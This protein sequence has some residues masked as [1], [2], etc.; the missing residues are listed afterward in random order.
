MLQTLAEG[1]CDS[2]PVFLF[3]R[4]LIVLDKYDAQARSGIFMIDASRGFAKD[5]PK[6]R[7][8]PR[9]VHRIVDAFTG[10]K[11]IEGY[12]RM[13]P[14]SEIADP[15]NNYNL[16]IPRYIDSSEPEDIQDLHAHIHG[17]IPN[18]DLD[19]LQPYWEAFPSLR[20]ELFA[21][22]REGYS[23]LKVEPSEIRTT[24][25]GSDEY[26]SFSSDTAATVQQWWAS[27]RPLLEGIDAETKPA[28]LIDDISE[29]LL[30]AFR[31]RP[32]I[33]E[34]GVYEQ[35]MSYWNDV[36]HDDVSLIVREGWTQ[37]VQPRPARMWRDKK[38]KPKYED[39]HIV[40]GI[41]A[42]AQRW[43]LDLLPPEHVIARY[44]ADEQAELDRLT[45]VRDAAT[46][47]V[48]EYIEEHAVEGG[49][50]FYAA[51]DEGKLPKK[52]AA[53][54]LK[55]LR[56]D[57]GDPEEV[58]A[59]TKVAALYR[60][61]DSAKKAVKDATT[62]LNEKTVAKYRVLTDADAQ[63]LVISSKWGMTLRGRIDAEREALV[64]VL[65]V[66]LRLLADR[67]ES[68]VAQLVSRIEVLAAKVATNL[69]E[70]GVQR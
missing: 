40:F 66:R 7:L 20:H 43:V 6:N 25:T 15:R 33:D 44:F 63:G 51:D 39:A 2:G 38:N 52:A 62:L 18:R 5:G 45:E 24:V 69:V 17:G 10:G 70:M 26:E 34:Y 53:D 3:A 64:Q 30:E 22:L 35:L 47:A 32:L 8:R 67:Y 19:A 68:T 12:S 65:V 29:A 13:V 56:R 55:D 48:S 46:L 59:L 49:L 28:G 11:E 42:N 60:A 58:E 16:N 14:V 37:A 9:D 1:P 23:E 36:M 54:Y 50:L 31:S 61:E 21:P 4:A 41:G 27:A 57:G